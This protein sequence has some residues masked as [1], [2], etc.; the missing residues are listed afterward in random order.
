MLALTVCGYNSVLQECLDDQGVNI[1]FEVSLTIGPRSALYYL[2]LDPCSTIDRR[3]QENF[4]SLSQMFMLQQVIS[5]LSESG[6]IST[7][8]RVE[9][10]TLLTDNCR[11]TNRTSNSSNFPRLAEFT[12]ELDCVDAITSALDKIPE[13]NAS[14]LTTM[15]LRLCVCAHVYM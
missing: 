2:W 8:T 3:R 10:E 1:I 11:N 9:I 7:M 12:D 15:S 14:N 13:F 6:A 5:Q 4:Y